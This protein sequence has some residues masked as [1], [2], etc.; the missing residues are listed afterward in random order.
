MA[1]K[2]LLELLQQLLGSNPSLETASNKVTV[3]TAVLEAVNK[4][5]KSNATVSF[6][7]SGVLFSKGAELPSPL[8]KFFS[9]LVEAAE[10]E[11]IVEKTNVDE[12]LMQL[13]TLQ[14]NLWVSQRRVVELENLLVV[15]KELQE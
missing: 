11:L 14:Q 7:P 10:E 3:A 13:T 12:L 5:S 2:N 9:R 6:D 8:N 4:L 15:A 1:E